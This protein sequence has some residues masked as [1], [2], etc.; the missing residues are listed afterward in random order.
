MSVP[1]HR[2]AVDNGTVVVMDRKFIDAWNRC[3]EAFAA[4]RESVT[5][6]LTWETKPAKSSGVF[7]EFRKQD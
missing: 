1:I 6:R 2:Y 7:G 3:N 4:W 5:A